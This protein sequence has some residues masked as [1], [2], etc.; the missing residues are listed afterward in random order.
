[1]SDDIIEIIRARHL[2]DERWRN[3]PSMICPQAHDD[4]S[5]LLAEVDRLSSDLRVQQGCCDGAAAQDA[6]V[7]RER[8]EHKAEVEKLRAV[9]ERLRSKIKWLIEDDERLHYVLYRIANPPPFA[10]CP[11]EMAQNATRGEHLRR[12]AFDGIRRALEGKP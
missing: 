10:D 9:I 1:M 5:F 6:H 12:E 3:I 4:R 7:R 2:R 11:V 8:E